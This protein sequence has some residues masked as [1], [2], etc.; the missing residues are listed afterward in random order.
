MSTQFLLLLKLNAE[1]LRTAAKSWRALSQ[2]L[3]AALTQ[4]RSKV[5]GP[6][7]QAQ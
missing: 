3:E 1:E 4:H 6:L 7:R 5:N 2:H